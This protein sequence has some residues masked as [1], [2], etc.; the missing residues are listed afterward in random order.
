MSPSNY[1]N[2]GIIIC[3]YGIFQVLELLK[4]DSIDFVIMSFVFLVF[5]AV[6]VYSD[7]K[8]DKK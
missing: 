8:G 2:F 1:T 5:F 6:D 3:L 7:A 4:Y